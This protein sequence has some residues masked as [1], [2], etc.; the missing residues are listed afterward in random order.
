[1]LHASR[2]QPSR[3]VDLIRGMALSFNSRPTDRGWMVSAWP[4]SY[5]AL[6]VLTQSAV[7]TPTL[8]AGLRQLMP[9]SQPLVLTK[10]ML[11]RKLFHRPMSPLGVR[12]MSLQNSD[13]ALPLATQLL[14]TVCESSA[15]IALVILIL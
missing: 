6:Q 8:V 7:N 9:K 5:L 4:S 11:R 10:P 12:L 2:F 15:A 13:V 3:S 14:S 1:M